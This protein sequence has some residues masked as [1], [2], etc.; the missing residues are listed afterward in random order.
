MEKQFNVV[1][2]RLPMVDAAAK[3]KG[4]A[5]FTDDLV[6]PGMLHG[7]ILRSPL[8]HARRLNVDVSKALRLPGVKGAVT[9]AEIPDRR[10][11]IV[12]KARDEYALA[13]GKVRYIGDDVAAV[14][15]IDPEI[16][17]EA[18]EL[19]K[20]D[21][22][23]LPAV[24]DPLEAIKEGAPVIHEG[25]PNNT[26]ASIR[27]EWG[28]V[29]AALARSDHVFEDAFYSQAVN[30]APMEPHAAFAQYDAQ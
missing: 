20:V 3:V 22:E 26:S 5:Q 4:S 12:P 29:E 10:Y 16:A 18:L 13:R 28:D 14:C 30:H 19:I 24:F 17:E 11:G 9:G 25:V 27:K 15:A 8:P 21:Y 7:K 23:E 6:F 1:G 2:R